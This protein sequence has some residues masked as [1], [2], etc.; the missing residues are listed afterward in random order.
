[1]NRSILKNTAKEHLT[2]KFGKWLIIILIPTI[3]VGILYGASGVLVES[4]NRFF[5][6]LDR[7]SVV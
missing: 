6:F 2:G 7:K 1:M 5:V 3:V 4:S